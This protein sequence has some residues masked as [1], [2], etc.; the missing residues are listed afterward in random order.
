MKFKLDGREYEHDGTL[1]VEEAM[2]LQDKT[3]LGMNEVDAAI[4]RG[5]PYAIAAWMM[6]LKKRA[7]E[8]ITWQNMMKLDIR[9]FEIVRDEEPAEQ[10]GA[11]ELAPDPTQPAGTTPESDTTAT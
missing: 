4:N 9:T 6:I 2:L 10:E 1:T 11:Q 8:V 3:G 5:N 7:G